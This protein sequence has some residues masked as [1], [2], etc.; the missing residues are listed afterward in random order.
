MI[1]GDR[2][3]ILLAIKVNMTLLRSI[4]MLCGT[5]IVLQKIFND[6]LFCIVLSVPKNI[7]MDLN[8]V[9]KIV[10]LIKQL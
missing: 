10:M 8:N 9:M 1:F 3:K 2:K 7:V 5:D 4:I 6:G